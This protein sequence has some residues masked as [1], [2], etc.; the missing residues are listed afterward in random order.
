MPRFMC[1][2]MAKTYTILMQSENAK[3]DANN[4]ETNTAAYISIW[5]EKRH[6]GQSTFENIM[7]TLSFK[8]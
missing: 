2:K 1:Y 6:G 5:Y 7:K 8:F 3:L 4:K